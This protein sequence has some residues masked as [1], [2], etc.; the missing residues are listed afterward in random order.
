MRRSFHS[1][2]RS[3]GLPCRTS[4]LTAISLPAHNDGCPNYART[5]SMFTRWET[6]GDETSRGRT[7][8]RLEPHNHRSHRELCA[9]RRAQDS[10]EKN[11]GSRGLSNAANPSIACGLCAAISTSAHRLTHNSPA[12][13]AVCGGSRCPVA[14]ADP[15]CVFLDVRCCDTHRLI[16]LALRWFERVTALFDASADLASARQSESSI[17]D[18]HW[19]MALEESAT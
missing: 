4:V 8:S 15:T 3:I 16:F 10:M 18:R 19:R 7:S 5:R 12:V 1:S 14:S 9:C 11:S 6:I 13:G 17:T 2:V